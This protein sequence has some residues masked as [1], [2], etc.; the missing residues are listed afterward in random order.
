MKKTILR[1]LI[2]CFVMALLCQW[3]VAATQVVFA[4]SYTDPDT[5]KISKYYQKP[6]ANAL[7]IGAGEALANSI[8]SYTGSSFTKD[9]AESNDIKLVYRN[10]DGTGICY[11]E[12]TT[13]SVSFNKGM[14]NYLNTGETPNLPTDTAAPQVAHNHLMALNL[15]PSSGVVLE[16]VGGLNMAIHE[17][18]GINS[19]YKKLIYVYEYR[20]LDSFEIVGSSRLV[21]GLGSGGELVSL[22]KSWVNVLPVACTPSEILSGNAIR[23]RIS[24]Q[25]LD[26]YGDTKYI[27]VQSQNLVYYDD[28]NGVIEPALAINGSVIL[29]AGE[30]KP[31]DWIVSIMVTPH[32]AYPYDISAPQP[33][34]PPADP[35]GIPQGENE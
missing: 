24:T 20:K 12:L 34:D 2:L 19:D 10:T 14:G 11:I 21:T 26:A 30:S 5:S 28:G 32:A 17:E 1:C 6:S 7:T 23:T 15:F 25:L 8:F 35:S 9:T 33:A 22:V 13:G 27:E 31:I 29:Q 4:G 16:R 3:A 18:S